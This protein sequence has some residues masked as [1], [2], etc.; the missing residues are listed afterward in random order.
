MV[1]HLFMERGDRAGLFGVTGA[2]SV[3]RHVGVTAVEVTGTNG[4]GGLVGRNGGRVTGSYATGRVS[5]SVSVGG[6]V[7]TNAGFIGGSYAAV[8]VAG[9]SSAGGLTGMNNGSIAAVYATGRVSG[10]RRV[11]GVAG[12]NRGRLAAVYATGRVSGDE[13][14]GGLA[15]VTE[16][17][18]VVTAGY[19]DTDTSGLP[20]GEAGRG[21]PTTALQAP[22]D[23]TGLYA[24]WNVDVDDDGVADAP[25]HFGTDAQYPALSLDMD[26]D[27]RATWQE[28]GRQ[29]RAGPTVTAVPAVGPVQ[30]ALAWTAADASA[31]T[32]SPPASYTVY[33]ETGGV[34]ETV[35][36]GVRGLGYLDRGMHSGAAYRYQVAA[37]VDG[38]EAVRSS[39]VTV[40]VPCAYEVTPLHRASA[41][42][43][44]FAWTGPTLIPGVTPIKRVHVAELRTALAEAYVAL[45]SSSTRLHGYRGGGRSRHP[46][47]APD[48]VA[49]RRRGAWAVAPWREA[50]ESRPDSLV[51]LSNTSRSRRS[52]G[53]F[54]PSAAGGR[55]A[56]PAPDAAGLDARGTRATGL[57]KWV[58]RPRIDNQEGAVTR[59]R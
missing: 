36:A 9:E 14:A 32:P 59:P 39:L 29:L 7:G 6:L 50:A 28:V 47:G 57:R 21:R 16:P 12:T 26:G 24:A 49:S 52:H 41:G 34:V 37:V 23:Y 38:G 10:T 2:S 20:A 27:G 56:R 25:W 40:E 18:G 31:W 55:E 19:W 4:V 11:G 46:G 3:V 54:L 58:V 5:G 17:L 51:H 22:I 15:G 35:A 30:V 44:P 42:L 43:L 45:G 13:E 48:G 53:R 33:R 1:R 8:V